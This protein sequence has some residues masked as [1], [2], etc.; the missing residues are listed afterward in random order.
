MATSKPH[1]IKGIGMNRGQVHTH[2][3]IFRSPTPVNMPSR[4]LSVRSRW[5]TGG[6]SAL[7]CMRC[8]VVLTA[9]EDEG[10]GVFVHWEVVELQLAFCIYGQSANTRQ[11]LKRSYWFVNLVLK[12]TAQSKIEHV[13]LWF[14]HLHLN[15]NATSRSIFQHEESGSELRQIEWSGHQS[16]QMPK[17]IFN[18]RCLKVWKN[19][20]PPVY[21][22]FCFFLST[23]QEEKLKLYV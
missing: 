1:W 10:T 19:T 7:C 22:L 11:R 5:H 8:W 3:M 2:R 18:L 20:V 13:R 9:G 16:S 17:Q 6:K 14:L 12:V 4:L 21:F 15:L 23:T